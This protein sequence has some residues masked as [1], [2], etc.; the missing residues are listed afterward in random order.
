MKIFKT[1]F[2]L[3]TLLFSYTLQSDYPF[4]GNI[5]TG[6]D[7][8]P[9]IREN[10][11]IY[12]VPKGVNKLFLK[13]K[14]IVEKFSK[15]GIEVE[16]SNRR[17][18]FIQVPL[19]IDLEY[20]ISYIS[21]EFLDRYP[22]MK[23]NSISVT[24]KY[25]IDTLP[26]EYSVIFTNRNLRKSNGYF[27]VETENR[28]RIYFKYSIDADITVLKSSQRVRRGEIISS[29]NSYTDEM[30]FERFR[31]E[32][33]T[34]D[35]LGAIQAK[36]YIPKDREITFRRV[37]KLTVIKK[38]SIVKGFIKDGGI[39]IEIEAIALEDGGI[40]DEVRIRS[41]DGAILRGVVKNSK[42]IKIL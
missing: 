27:Y 33:V 4:S 40:G 18:R 26:E 17:V 29:H 15:Y 21:D 22:S 20:L 16:Y 38:G 2:I 42:L 34:E 28:D 1:I 25:Y 19:E 39:Y 24:P 11:F 13:S 41:Y 8:F 9:E 3:Q 37:E 12:K 32:Y 5:I 36:T 10:I 35:E 31:S 30:K 14:D 7:L 6:Q 23:I